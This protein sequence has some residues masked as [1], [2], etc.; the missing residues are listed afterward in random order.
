MLAQ[1]K[2]CSWPARVLCV[3]VPLVREPAGMRGE[4]IGIA[5]PAS[6]G[7]F[8]LGAQFCVPGTVVVS[9]AGNPVD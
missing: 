5:V 3:Q 1:V 2:P 8:G 7:H 4:C 9:G 6:N